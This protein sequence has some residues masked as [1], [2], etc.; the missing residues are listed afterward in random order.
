MSLTRIVSATA[1]AAALSLTAACGGSS[2]D[3]GEGALGSTADPTPTTPATSAAIT[4]TPTPTA[5]KT[6]KPHVT[7]TPTNSPTAGDGDSVGDDEPF[8]AGG[9]VCGKLTASQVGEV[10]GAGVRGSGISG[11]GCEFDHADQRLPAATVKDTAYAGMDAAKTETTSAVE[12]EPQDVPG[13]GTAAFVVTGSV[14]GGP[15][16]Q[17]AG[18]VH[19]GSRTITVFVVQHKSLSEAAVRDLVVRL[20]RLVAAPRG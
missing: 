6:R 8:T 19:V 17:G 20:L 7:A 12:G 16:V 11:G 18:A 4:P 2:K 13:I 3:T 15:E 10:I 14:F 5:T 1:L 9:G